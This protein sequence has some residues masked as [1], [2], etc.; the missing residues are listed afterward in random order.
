MNYRC[1]CES[2]L[3]RREEDAGEGVQ[4]IEAW[5]R[6]EREQGESNNS[7]LALLDSLCEA[8]RAVVEAERLYQSPPPGRIERAEVLARFDRLRDVLDLCDAEKARC[9]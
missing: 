2:C 3:T 4:A 1:M 5:L 9:P 8:A 7:T 6:E